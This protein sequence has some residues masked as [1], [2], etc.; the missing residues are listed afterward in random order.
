VVIILETRSSKDQAARYLLPKLRIAHCGANREHCNPHRVFSMAEEAGGR[1]VRVGVQEASHAASTSFLMFSLLLSPGISSKY[2]ARLRISPAAVDL[3]IP[4]Q[5]VQIPG[6]PRDSAMDQGAARQIYLAWVLLLWTLIKTSPG[7]FPGPPTLIASI[8]F[9]PEFYSSSPAVFVHIIPRH[10]ATPD[11]RSHIKQIW[12]LTS[13]PLLLL[14]ALR[15]ASMAS[16]GA[17][18]VLY[19]PRPCQSPVACL[20]QTRPRL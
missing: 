9:S 18:S 19:S 15:P 8:P 3:R 7:H 14:A 17:A 5:G 10:S 4:Q 13:T 16:T 20:L 12:L 6:C 2:P 1:A 11:L